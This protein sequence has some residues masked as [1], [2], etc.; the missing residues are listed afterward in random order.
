M[1][2]LL[3]ALDQLVNAAIGGYADETISARAWRLRKTSYS[4]R[5][6]RF[7]IDG[8]FF[9]DANHC[10]E[11]YLNEMRRKQLPKEYAYNKN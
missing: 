8:V 3:I 11:S 5:V 1:K 9:W 10:Q 4:W 7:V 6:T 2:Q